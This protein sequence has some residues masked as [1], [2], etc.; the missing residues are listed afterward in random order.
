[1][2]DFSAFYGQTIRTTCKI[3]LSLGDARVSHLDLRD[4]ADAAVSALTNDRH[5]NKTYDLSGPEALHTSQV[6]EQLLGRKAI[7]FRQ[8]AIDERSAWL[9]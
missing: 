7:P 2:Q 6:A 3:F 9:D 5:L 4:L 8:F 1:M